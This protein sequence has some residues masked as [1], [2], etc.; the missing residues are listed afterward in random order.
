[1]FQMLVGITSTPLHNYLFENNGNLQFTNRSTDWGFDELNF[2]HGAAYADLDNDGDLDLV[3]NRMNEPAGIF[4]NNCNS[5]KKEN[6]FLDI[7][8]QMQ[9]NNF[10]ALGA[11]LQVFAPAGINYMENYPVHGF[12]SSMQIPLHTGFRGTKIDSIQITWPDDG[13]QTIT[14]NIPIDTLITIQYKKI[15]ILQ[16]TAIRPSAFFSNAENIIPFKHIE[17]EENDFKIQPLMP[18]ML[19]FA[20]P[21]LAGCD[22]NKDGLTDFYIGGAQNQAGA[23][24]L[25]QSIGDF[26]LMPQAD[27]IKDASS[28]DE[29]AVFFDADGDG[30]ADLYVVSGG[31]AMP[32]NDASYQDRLYINE[33]NQFIKKEKALPYET[34]AGSVVKAIDFDNDGDMDLFIGGRVVPGRYP[35]TPESGLLQNDGKGN[36]TNVTAT[37]APALQ[38][39]GMITDAVWADINKDGNQELIVCGEWMPV[40]IFEWTNGILINVTKK[41]FESS[42]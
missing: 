11:K 13:V 1:M 25:Q 30:D 40:D 17:D 19:S 15:P 2:S 31:Y 35:V 37:M 7:N 20:G 29:D 22:I 39:A 28:E 12:Q 9:G 16:N 21:H 41:Y 33:N 10:F 38:Y 27:F 3:V 4:K 42:E 36:F 5:L 18:N 8:L 32:E 26:I 6:H 14:E 34:I 24:L 23:I